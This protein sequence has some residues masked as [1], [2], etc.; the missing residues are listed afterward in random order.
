MWWISVALLFIMV[1]FQILDQSDT[2]RMKFTNQNAI[3]ILAVLLV[4]IVSAILI[5]LGLIDV[6]ITIVSLC[7]LS[8]GVLAGYFIHRNKSKSNVSTTS[9]KRPVQTRKLVT[10]TLQRMNCQVEEDENGYFE[11]EY[12]GV[13][14]VIEAEDDC[15]YINLVWPWC[16]T[17]PLYD[18]DAYSRLRK[19]VNDLNSLGTCSLF[20]FPHKETD[21]MVVHLKANMLFM[22]EIGPIDAYLAGAISGLFKIVNQ[23]NLEMEKMKLEETATPR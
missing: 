3:I 9:N 22:S 14:F 8:I 2:N 17:I 11:F 18:A 19:I 16:Y 12:Q 4:I 1:L 20:Y 7:A 10:D 15:L 21:E 13:H 23:L 6:T 5:H